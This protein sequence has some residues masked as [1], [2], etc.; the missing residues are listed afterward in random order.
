M[1]RRPPE[2]T[3]TDTRFPYTTLFRSLHPDQGAA[4][5]GRNLS[6]YAAR[7]RLWPDRPADQRRHRR[8]REAVARRREAAEPG[9]RLPDEE[10]QDHRPYGRGQARES[11]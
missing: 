9:R 1:I 7:G 8:G 11:G 2:S 5:F 3:L 6:L 4:A 10:A